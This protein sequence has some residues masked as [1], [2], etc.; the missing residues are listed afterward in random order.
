VYRER[1]FLRAC[2]EKRII[3]RQHQRRGT[4][5]KNWRQKTVV[6]WEE[7]FRK[8]RE[9]LQHR[10][11]D[12]ILKT[13]SPPK[14]NWHELHKSSVRPRQP[15]LNIWLLKIIFR[16]INDGV[17]TIKP[18][19]QTTGNAHV[20]PSDEPFLALF[21]TSGR[22]YVWRTT[23]EAYIREYLVPTMK[24]RGGSVMIWSAISWYSILFVSL[25]LFMAELLQGSR[26]TGWVIRCI[27]WSR[28]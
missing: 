25:L 9:L 26:W 11:Q 5:G 24:H 15:L 28:H 1:Q 17:T 3:G 16:C 21:L 22:I 6:P 4:V 10:C 20:I 19:H 8:I 18:G 13:L 7:L 2:G 23:K 27:L 14:R 12:F